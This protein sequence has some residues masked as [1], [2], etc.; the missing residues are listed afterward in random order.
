MTNHIFCTHQILNK[1]KRWAYKQSV[2]QLFI[3]FTKPH[4]S[5]RR[6]FLYNILIE[7]VSP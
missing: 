4:D 5:V 7:L 3:D 2:H 6:E 1:K